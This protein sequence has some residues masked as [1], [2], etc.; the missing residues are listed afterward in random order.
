MQ[1]EKDGRFNNSYINQ[2]LGVKDIENVDEKTN[3]R[4]K[5]NC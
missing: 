3:A 5:K 4:K 2:L 1:N